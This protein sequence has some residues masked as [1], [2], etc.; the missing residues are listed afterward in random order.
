MG[1]MEMDG[2]QPKGLFDGLTREEFINEAY[3]LRYQQALDHIAYDDTQK[4]IMH[5]IVDLRMSAIVIG[6][7][8]TGKTLMAYQCELDLRQAGVDARHI[9]ALELFDVI[10]SRMAHDGDALRYTLD[11]FGRPEALFIDEMDKSY[12]SQT[13]YLYFSSLIDSRY[14]DMK[15]TVLFGN[16]RDWQEVIGR[17]GQSNFDRLSQKG[18]G[19]RVTMTRGSYRQEADRQA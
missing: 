7:N 19:F 11:R 1:L 9:Q 5:A 8:G 18:Y 12:G 2:R 14:C 10:R 13:E 3:P 15:Q 16:F 4:A 17:I 6:S